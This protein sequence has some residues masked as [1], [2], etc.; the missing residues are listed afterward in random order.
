MQEKTPSSEALRLTPK[1]TE[2][3]KKVL[4]SIEGGRTEIKRFIET[5]VDFTFGSNTPSNELERTA[6]IN[7]LGI[8]ESSRKAEVFAILQ[9]L[10]TQIADG[11]PTIHYT[12]GGALHKLKQRDAVELLRKIPGGL[13]EKLRFC[14]TLVNYVLGSNTPDQPEMRKMAVELFGDLPST[15]EN[16]KA[17][18]L[19]LKLLI[20]TLQLNQQSLSDSD[21][22][23]VGSSS[24]SG[25]VF[26]ESNDSDI[27][28]GDDGPS[29]PVV[30][31]LKHPTLK[32]D[33]ALWDE[34]IAEEVRKK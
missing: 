3:A 4:Q 12:E 14:Q 16:K 5:L 31:K 20:D 32:S 13:K 8:I 1:Q 28:L 23:L 6:A 17:A 10:S 27:I 7:L 19:A 30:K 11:T 15:P 22:H 26:D 9:S 33:D 34:I 21:V 18:Y 29:A 25:H 24:G 2:V